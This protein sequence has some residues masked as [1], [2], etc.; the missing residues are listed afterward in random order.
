[1]PPLPPRSRPATLE[2]CWALIDRLYDGIEELM[3]IVAEQRQR[4][5]EL[6]RRLGLTSQNSSKPPSSDAPFVRRP[7]KKE[8]T[9]RKP[10]GQP[11]HEGHHRELLPPDQVDE[12]VEHWPTQCENCQA[13]LP[14]GIRV[15]VDEPLRHQVTELPPVSARVAEH[16]MHTQQCPGCG[17]ATPC[18]W[19]E[20]LPTGAFGPRLASVVSVLTGC[21]RMATRMA[22]E[23]VHDLFGARISLGSVVACEQTASV[24]VAPAVEEAREYVQQQAVAHADETGWV[25]GRKRAWLWVLATTWVVVFLVHAQRSR[26]AAREIL[27]KFAGILVSDRWSVYRIHDG[28][29]QICWAH[30]RRDF[31]AMSELSGKAGRL[32]KELV[33]LTA[34][35]FR[36]WN[37]VRD[38][39]MSRAEFQRRM[40]PLRARVEA[41]LQQGVESAR[42]RVSGMCWDIAGRHGDALWTFVDVEGVEPTNNNAER[43]L[44][45]AVIWRKSSYGTHSEEGSRFVERM[46]TV[47]ATLRAQ[48]RN[49]LAYVTQAVEA[50]LRGLPPPSLLPEQNPQALLAAA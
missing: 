36:W 11:G 5:E 26:K 24:A 33:R 21:Y 29:R 1:M 38:G 7:P 4:I 42:P 6:E 25:Q 18:P 28:L 13:P 48:N 2:E 17:W 8:P 23:A 41:L 12:V 34:R 49:V 37:R 15:E 35:M 3:R 32:G 44:R 9:G 30:L 47:R 22:E 20:G 39:P 19:P 45:H 27:G 40:K 31:Q 43:P 14:E 50:S 46:L 16:R 10:G